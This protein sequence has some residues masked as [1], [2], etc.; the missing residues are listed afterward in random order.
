MSWLGS[1]DGEGYSVDCGGFAPSVAYAA[2]P[3]LVQPQ[4]AEKE[5]ST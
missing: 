5:R 2:K 3:E 4:M 1:L